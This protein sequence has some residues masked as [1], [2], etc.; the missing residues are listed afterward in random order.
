MT[1][2]AVDFDGTN[3]YMTKASLTGA[4]DSKKGIFSFRGRLDGGD[5]TDRQLMQF[6][7]FVEFTMRTTNKL[8][9]LAL[10][11]ASATAIDVTTNATFTASANWFHILASWDLAVPVLH[12]YV[13][14]ASASLAT[15]T[16]VN[17]TIKWT[18]T[19]CTI[20]ARSNGTQKWNG[21]MCEFYFNIGDYLDLTVEA[22]RRLFDPVSLGA[23]GQLPTGTQPDI[24]Q[25][26]SDADA[27]TVFA[28]NKG[29]GGNFTITGTLDICSSIP[30]IVGVLAG[31]GT[32]ALT[33]SSVM[34]GTGA[35]V[36]SSTTS[37][38]PTGTVLGAGSLVGSSTIQ[39]IGSGSTLATGSLAGS[40]LVSFSLN[41]TLIA[42]T[43]EQIAGSSILAFV[44]T[45]AMIDATAPTNPTVLTVSDSALG[46]ITMTNT[47][48]GSATVDDASPS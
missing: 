41:A 23:T 48:I 45:A 25:S 38:S 29:S 44:V 46:T 21:C 34:T 39:F 28:T 35:L 37:F 5:G 24:Y 27:A 9:L 19:N 22:N 13:N 10:D 4:A 32:L 43:I 6:L 40:S 42:T 47:G 36:G 8:Q 7:N 15:N 17:K 2:S 1:I 16:V 30:P 31:S 3:D 33:P 12:L 18:S 20:G 26:I 14:D 11:A